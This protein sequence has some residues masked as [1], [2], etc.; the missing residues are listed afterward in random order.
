MKFLDLDVSLNG[1]MSKFILN[2]IAITNVKDKERSLKCSKR[3]AVSYLQ[4]APIRLS[5][6]F[7]RETLQTKMDWH[8]IVK[9]I[10][11]K[12]LQPTPTLPSKTII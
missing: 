3:K 7:S 4:R 12:E 6:D 5:A 10:K 1:S 11:S 8:K 2:G 9:V